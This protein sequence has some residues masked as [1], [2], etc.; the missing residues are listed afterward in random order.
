[1]IFLEKNKCNFCCKI[2]IKN[3][4][5]TKLMWYNIYINN[6]SFGNVGGVILMSGKLTVGVFIHHLDNDYSKAFL[7]GT[8]AAANDL[9]VNLAI[10]PGR[11]LDCQLADRRYTVYE[12][13]NNVVYS[14]AS[15]KS[16]DAL[17]VSAG[18]IATCVSH[19]EF[20]EFLDGYEGLPLLTTETKFE[21]YPCIR[22]SGSGIKE[23]VSHLVHEHGRKHIAFVSGPEGNTDADERLNHYKEA[24][25]ENG[26]EFDPD[27]VTYGNFS[28]YC[29]DIVS[30]L[31]DRNEGKIDAICFAND[32]MCRGGYKAIESKGLR[33]GKDIAVTGYDDSEVAATLRPMLTTVRADASKLG[34]RAVEEAV[35][36][37]KGEKVEDICIDST[38]V[39][40]FSCGCSFQAEQK[41]TLDRLDEASVRKAVDNILSEHIQR[42][43]VSMRKHDCIKRLHEFAHKLISYAAGADISVE[44]LFSKSYFSR[45][46]DSD[47]WKLVSPEAFLRIMKSIRSA[48]LS[49]CEGDM[50]GRKLNVL[51]ILEGSME[52]ASECIVNMHYTTMNDITFTHFLIGNITKDMTIYDSDDEKCY[53]SIVNDLYRAHVDSSFVYTFEE[54]IIHDPKSEWKLPETI[55][56]RA[57]NDGDKLAA[58]TGEA[59]KLPSSRIITNQYTPNDRNRIMV[60]S[61][62]FMNEEQYGVIVCE[63]ENEYFT[64][65]YSITP[66][67]CSAIKLTNLVAKLESSLDAAQSRNNV[68]NRMSMIDELTGV[69]NRRG[70]YVSANRILKAAENEGRQAAIIFGDL[71]NLKKVNDT[72]GHDDGDY[73]IVSCAEFLKKSLRTTDVVG[74]IGGDEFA[75]FAICDDAD[76]IAKLP[77]RIKGIA[78]KHNE[79]SDKPY[80]VTVSIGIYPIICSPELNIQDFMDKADNALYEDKKKKNPDIM[81]HNM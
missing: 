62:L 74:R 78:A 17:I 52:V 67:I 19:E 77:S 75:A 80:N 35:H 73:A 51:K 11:A 21:G 56:L 25:A 54:P 60:V 9:D 15:S 65:I 64:Y 31:I 28:E 14:F 7:K 2:H 70:F 76:I 32:M 30:D 33:V 49:A 1:M 29:V 4:E 57:Y 39:F 40:R 63:M 68:L 5:E 12:Y 13:Q 81:K 53:F 41:V 23:L 24:L 38:P 61:P 55:L 27:L 3:L 34:Y 45:I 36:M 6:P 66:Q 59:C 43:E 10:F 72:F 16:M 71:D 58:V 42:Y 26:L 79:V 20:K 50:M 22:L 8:A 46:M 48:S 44:E 37:A 18:T 69:Y 47:I